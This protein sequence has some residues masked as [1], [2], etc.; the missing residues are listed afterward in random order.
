MAAANIPCFDGSQPP[1]AVGC[2]ISCK[3]FPTVPSLMPTKP[4]CSYGFDDSECKLWQ[5]W[6]R[7]MCRP[8]YRISWETLQPPTSNQMGPLHLGCW[9]Q[10]TSF[11]H[12]N[13][14]RLKLFMHPRH[15]RSIQMHTRQTGQQPGGCQHRGARR[16][17]A[18][19]GWLVSVNTTHA[20]AAGM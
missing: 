1:L 11:G 10:A 7:P 15:V 2:S 8:A 17:S 16:S 20:G 3:P 4:A 12:A 13:L 19:L 5:L 6:P 18:N 9:R 14:G